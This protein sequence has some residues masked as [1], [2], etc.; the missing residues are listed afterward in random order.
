MKKVEES[1][2]FRLNWNFLQLSSPSTGWRKG[3]NWASLSR[4]HCR[5]SSRTC[6]TDS[7]QRCTRFSVLRCSSLTCSAVIVIIYHIKVTLSRGYLKNLFTGY[8]QVSWHPACC[9]FLHNLQAK[10]S[11]LIHKKYQK[12]V[13]KCYK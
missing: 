4:C 5:L 13:C 10:S 3:P 6:R 11:K 12:N 2:N 9:A 1:F 7:F 8:P